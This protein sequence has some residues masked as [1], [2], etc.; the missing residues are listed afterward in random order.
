MTKQRL[1]QECGEKRTYTSFDFC[2]F[3]YIDEYKNKKMS[4]F[5]A[6]AKLHGYLCNNKN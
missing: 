2:Y 3:F 5:V 1:C 6:F 4:T